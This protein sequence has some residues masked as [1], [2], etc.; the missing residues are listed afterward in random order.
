V[1]ALFNDHA[2]RDRLQLAGVNSINWARVMAQTVYFLTSAATL[3]A[4]LRDVVYSVPTGNFGD[5]FAGYVAQRM[6][7]G[8][9]QLIVATNVNDILCRTLESG[10][11]EPREVVP[12]ASPSMDIQVSSNF[13]RL[14]FEVSGSGNARDPARVAALMQSLAKD[15]TFE[16]AQREL[17]LI[18]QSFQYARTSEDETRET[19]ARVHAE[20]GYVLDPHTAVGL[21]AARRERRRPHLPRVTLATA[22]PAK[23]PDA[24]EAAIGTRPVLPERLA[25]VLEEKERYDTLPKD[26]AGLARFI[27]ERARTGRA[28]A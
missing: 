20:T 4:P 7:Y 25:R 15:G 19:I 17:D 10:R 14:V 16:L 12:T 11:Y 27:A 1:K 26:Y 21:A 8:I 6:G 13:E 9:A 24:V 3:G 22:H 18:R 23:F 28:A 2:L 5:V